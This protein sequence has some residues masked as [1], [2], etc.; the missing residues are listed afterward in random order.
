MCSYI[1]GACLLC[2]S[3]RQWGCGGEGNPRSMTPWSWN[4][5]GEAEEEWIYDGECGLGQEL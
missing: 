3:S 1:F 2:A 5:V 4:T